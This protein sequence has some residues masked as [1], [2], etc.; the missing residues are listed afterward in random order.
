MT[1]DYDEID[2]TTQE[3]SIEENTFMDSDYDNKSLVDVNLSSK[4]ADGMCQ[5][6]RPGHVT[7]SRFE[8]MNPLRSDV[9]VAPSQSDSTNPPQLTSAGFDV[10]MNSLTDGNTHSVHGHSMASLHAPGDLKSAKEQSWEDND[11]DRN[12]GLCSRPVQESGLDPPKYMPSSGPESFAQSFQSTTTLTSHPLQRDGERYSKDTGMQVT[13]QATMTSQ[14]EPPNKDCVPVI[15]NIQ[16]SDNLHIGLSGGGAEL[17]QLPPLLSAGY[18][19]PAT[20]TAS[21]SAHRSV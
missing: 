16:R 10:Q 8:K 2:S 9:V 12:D 13:T 4:S 20:A 21:G 11:T 15:I 1:T 14:P 18:G 7:E 17:T 6:S 3:E 5:T 19:A